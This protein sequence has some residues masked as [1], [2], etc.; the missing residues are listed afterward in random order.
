MW[1]KATKRVYRKVKR[2]TRA[3]SLELEEES[4]LDC[5]D[6]VQAAFWFISRPG[7]AHVTFP[8]RTYN[9]SAQLISCMAAHPMARSL[10]SGSRRQRDKGGH[11]HGSSRHGP[12]LIRVLSRRCVTH[13]QQGPDDERGAKTCHRGSNFTSERK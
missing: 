3:T 11:G 9:A 10:V 7:H 13:S 5:G 1:K 2:R 12:S 6:P 4:Q 8:T